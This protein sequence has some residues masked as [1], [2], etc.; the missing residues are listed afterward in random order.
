MKLVASH[1][2]CAR[3]IVHS[4][5]LL[6]SYCT[7]PIGRRNTGQVKVTLQIMTKSIKSSKAMSI[8]SAPCLGTV[9]SSLKIRFSGLAVE[10]FV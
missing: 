7:V 2:S 3:E 1:H 9:G 10:I 4:M 5:A 8:K 6:L